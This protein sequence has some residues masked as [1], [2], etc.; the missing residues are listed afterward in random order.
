MTLEF[1]LIEGI[2]E[3]HGRV[4]PLKNAHTRQGRD[5]ARLVGPDGGHGSGIRRKPTPRGT[6]K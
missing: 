1:K 2:E 6:F 5:D 4:F 3:K